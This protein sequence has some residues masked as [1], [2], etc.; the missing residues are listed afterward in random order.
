MN[1]DERPDARLVRELGDRIGYGNMMHLASGLW[2]KELFTSY[3]IVGGEFVVGPC[4]SAVVPCECETPS[5]CDWCCGCGWVTKH[6][7][8]M[9]DV[10][11]KANS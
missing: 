3:G 7:K 6:V 4:K 5:K 8:K 2:A 10:D 9:K 1:P 11:G